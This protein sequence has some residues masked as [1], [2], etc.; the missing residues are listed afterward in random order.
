MSDGTGPRRGGEGLGGGEADTL[1]AVW[2]YY[3]GEYGFLVRKPNV[4]L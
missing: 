4:R 2:Q 1:L 3:W